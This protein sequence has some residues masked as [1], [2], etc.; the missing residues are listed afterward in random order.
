MITSPINE[1][2]GC[3]S[4]RKKKNKLTVNYPLAAMLSGLALTQNSGIFVVDQIGN[5]E[6][7]WSYGPDKSF[8]S[9]YD[10]SFIG[11][12]E[13]EIIRKLKFVLNRSTHDDI[14]S[15]NV[16]WIVNV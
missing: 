4:K 15:H 13:N 16:F 12:L 6:R 9:T 2:N 3:G 5:F 1:E 10:L 7:T 8:L 14:I 11:S